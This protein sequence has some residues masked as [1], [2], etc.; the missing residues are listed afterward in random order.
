MSW[1]S[2]GALPVEAPEAVVTTLAQQADSVDTEM[3][4]EVASPHAPMTSSS[5]S[6]SAFAAMSP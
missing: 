5:G 3:A 1:H 4:L 6:L 2:R